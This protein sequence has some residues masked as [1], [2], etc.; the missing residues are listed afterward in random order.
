MKIVLDEGAKMPTR[1]HDADAGLDL[2]ARETQII[3]AGG[4]VSF[5][6]GVHIELP[7]NTVGQLESKSGL[8]RYHGIFCTGTID[9]GYTGSIVA[10]LYNLGDTDF[11]VE[12]GQ[13]ITQLV[14][15][16]I[17]KPELEQVEKLEHTERG[18]G[19]FGSTGR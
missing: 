5:D 13:K 12:A 7:T 4:K 19:G 9:E 6:T 3:R 2:Y 15:Y 11:T 14:I 17:I 16:P 18:N 10:T 1:G 8:F